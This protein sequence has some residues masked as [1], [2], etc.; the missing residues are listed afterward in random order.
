MDHILQF[1]NVAHLGIHV[2]RVEEIAILT[3]NVGEV[4]CVGVT[5]ATARNSHRAVRIA[6]REVPP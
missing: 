6:V 2:T 1:E 3:L 4:L 5:I